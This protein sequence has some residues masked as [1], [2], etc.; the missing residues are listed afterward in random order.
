MNEKETLK[1]I[2]LEKSYRE[3]TFKLT[4]GR[5]SDL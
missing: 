5:K 2:I 4:S 3:G 1:R